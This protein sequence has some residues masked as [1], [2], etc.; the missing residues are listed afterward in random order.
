MKR[1]LILHE[2][3]AHAPFTAL[4]TLA[5]IGLLL[6]LVALRITAGSVLMTLGKPWMRVGFE[7][8]GL[9]V[10]SI[11]AFTLIASGLSEAMPIALACG[12]WSMATLGFLI[13]YGIRGWN[14]KPYNKPK[15]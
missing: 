11:A 13:L 4:G 15:H 5:G 2:L 12:E 1:S 9:L 10:L 7:V 6:G 14:K 3:R 8:V